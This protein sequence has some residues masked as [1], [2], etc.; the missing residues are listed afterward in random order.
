MNAIISVAT[1]AN[2]VRP[3][4]RARQSLEQLPTLEIEAAPAPEVSTTLRRDHAPGF[5]AVVGEHRSERA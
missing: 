4:Y 1:T 2:E 5:L 3:G